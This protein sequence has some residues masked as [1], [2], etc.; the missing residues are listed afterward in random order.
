TQFTLFAGDNGFI[1]PGGTYTATATFSDGSTF[2]GL[3]TIVAPEDV[4]SVAH[5]AVP[6][7]TSSTVVG[8]AT[9]PGSTVVTFS[10]IRDIEGTRVADGAKVGI[11]VVDSATKD[12]RGNAIHSAGGLIL[13]GTPAAN[14]ANFR[15]FTVSSGA[16][17]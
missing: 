12:P 2:V 11:A 10:D 8:S 9:L 1:V 15:I 16:V 7:A 17:S 14:N 3:F 4:T 5:P 6:S 13:D